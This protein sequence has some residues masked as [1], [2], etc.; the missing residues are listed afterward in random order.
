MT[1][2]PYAYQTYLNGRHYPIEVGILSMGAPT[3]T[4]IWGYTMM[5]IGSYM[6]TTA[7]RRIPSYS[8]GIH[9]GSA[10]LG[11]PGSA[12]LGGYGK[13]RI[14]GRPQPNPSHPLLQTQEETWSLD[15]RILD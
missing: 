6:Y 5:F 12:W 7:S 2:L 11:I 10:K 4:H 13:N 1:G 14:M 8:Y 15:S 3:L 9:I